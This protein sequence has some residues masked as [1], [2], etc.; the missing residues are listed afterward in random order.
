MIQLVTIS[1]V[2]S[3]VDGCNLAS[4]EEAV[5]RNRMSVLLD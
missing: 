1:I 3:K 5:R 2:I 4:I